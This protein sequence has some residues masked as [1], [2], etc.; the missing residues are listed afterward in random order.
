MK[1]FTVNLK[2]LYNVKGGKVTAYIT[3]APFDQPDPDFRRPA[4]IVVPGGGYN[5]VSKREGE[6]TGNYFTYVGYQVFVLEYLC[7]PDGVKYPE[8]LYELAAAVD[9]VK[10]NAD[11]FLVKKDKVFA[12]GFSAGGHLVA[13]LAVNYK[14]AQKDLGLSDCTLTATGLSY[15][16]ISPEYRHKDSFD[17][18]LNG[19]TDDEKKGLYD[20]LCL[21]KLVT[22]NTPPSFLWTTSED[23]DVPPVNALKYAEALAEHNI[24]FELHVYPHGWHGLANCSEEINPAKPSFLKKNSQ[25]ISDCADF[26]KEF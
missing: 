24:K 16:V 14:K 15:P 4:V 10:K 11:E 1:T 23:N 5:M 3:E 25:W 13:N 9:Y 8:Q 2:E 19:Y 7:R 22:E 17:C 26:F 6:P 12:V 20:E 18:L 21:D